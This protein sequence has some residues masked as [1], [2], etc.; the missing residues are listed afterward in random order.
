[1]ASHQLSRHDQDPRQSQAKAVRSIHALGWMLSAGVLP[2][3]S[4]R[5]PSSSRIQGTRDESRNVTMIS[6]WAMSPVDRR[7]LFSFLPGMMVPRSSG[8]DISPVS[9]TYRERYSKPHVIEKKKSA[10]AASNASW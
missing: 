3:C 7:L 6:L 4:M 8:F 1:M 9:L 10:R 5:P 2:F